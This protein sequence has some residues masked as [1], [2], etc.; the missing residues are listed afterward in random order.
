MAYAIGVSLLVQMVY[1]LVWYILA[2]AVRIEVPF[3]ALLVFVPFVSLAAMLPI[4]LSGLGVREGVW[5]L[6]LAP[7][8]IPVADAIR[9]SLLYYGCGLLLGLIGGILFISSGIEIRTTNHAD[10]RTSPTAVIRAS[11]P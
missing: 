10:S 8:G 4:T 2:L 9:F 5:A 7:V 11:L 1:I 6:L 3:L